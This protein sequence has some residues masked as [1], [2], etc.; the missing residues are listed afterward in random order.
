MSLCYA[1]SCLAQSPHLRLGK[2]HKHLGCRLCDCHFVEDRGPIVGDDD[3][4]IGLANLGR[5]RLSNG[6]MQPCAAFDQNTHHLVH[7]PRTQTGTNGIG[8]GFCS[9]DVV[10][11]DILLLGV[12]TA[13]RDN[14]RLALA[15]SA[16]HNQWCKQVVLVGVAFDLSSTSFDCHADC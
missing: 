15:A 3:L 16:T 4:P 1:V 6:C 9:L 8:N 7:A 12:L 10:D 13:R 5:N 2:L 11:P 14:L